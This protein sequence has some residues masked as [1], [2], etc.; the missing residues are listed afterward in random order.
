MLAISAAQIEAIRI[1]KWTEVR[2][3][4]AHHLNAHFSEQLR[5]LELQTDAIH[6]PLDKALAHAR[7]L[8]FESERDLRI[9]AEA[10]VT[11]D[12]S[13]PE[14]VGDP[15]LLSEIEH[16]KTSANKAMV[17]DEFLVLHELTRDS[18]A[19]S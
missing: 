18:D 3:R 4:I 12:F 1:A 10:C 17:V 6:D 9:F 5:H 13:F 8:G 16:A 7:S 2:G 11:T 19:T 15:N 14:S